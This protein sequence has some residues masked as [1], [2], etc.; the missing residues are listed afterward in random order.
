MV[1]DQRQYVNE[2]V[3]AFVETWTVPPIY[4]LFL[5]TEEYWL[6]HTANNV[7]E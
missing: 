4:E 2:I 3:E 6:G 7:Q 5:V 1:E